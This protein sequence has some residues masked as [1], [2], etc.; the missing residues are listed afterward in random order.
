MATLL[1][2]ERNVVGRD[3]RSLFGPA[4]PLRLHALLSV[5][6]VIVSA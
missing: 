6:T 4:P 2:R 3:L 5:I 1:T